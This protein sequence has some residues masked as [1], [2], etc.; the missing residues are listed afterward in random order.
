MIDNAPEFSR[1]FKV[2]TLGATPVAVE[3]A[4]DETERNALAARFGLQAI[5]SLTARARIMLRDKQPVA[6]GSFSAALTQ[7]CIATADAVPVQVELPLKLRFIDEAAVPEVGEIE[8]TFDAYDDMALS[9]EMIDLGEGVAH[10]MA[11]ALDPFPR[12]PNADRILRAAGV[13]AEGEEPRGAF[14]GL[15]DMLKG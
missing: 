1:C 6:E 15:K 12:G 13:I 10:T 14:A 11:L 9:G 5:A 4:A 8:L 2:D 3:I 7:T